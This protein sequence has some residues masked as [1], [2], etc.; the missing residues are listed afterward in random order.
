MTG[1]GDM[2]VAVGLREADE[3]VAIGIGMMD[4]GGTLVR[5]VHRQDQLRENGGLVCSSSILQFS[6]S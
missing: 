6:A 5:A 4:G 1:I 3:A 2:I